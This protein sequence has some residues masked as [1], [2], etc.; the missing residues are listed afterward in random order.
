MVGTAAGKSKCITPGKSKL[1]KHGSIDTAPGANPK[2]SE[3]LQQSKSSKPGVDRRF[4]AKKISKENLQFFKGLVCKLEPIFR[5][6]GTTLEEFVRNATR[7]TPRDVESSG[8]PVPKPYK[9][10]GKK[11]SESPTLHHTLP[12]VNKVEE[13]DIVFKRGASIHWRPGNFLLRQ[14]IF[15]NKDTYRQLCKITRPKL[16]AM[17]VDYFKKTGFRFLEILNDKTGVPTYVEDSRLCEKFMQGLREKTFSGNS[18]VLPSILTDPNFHKVQPDWTNAQRPVGLLHK[19]NQ[20]KNN[21]TTKQTVNGTVK[22]K[23]PSKHDKQPISDRKQSRAKRKTSTEQFSVEAKIRVREQ[24]KTIGENPDL[25]SVSTAIALPHPVVTP[26]SSITTPSQTA[27]KNN[28][29]TL[30]VQRDLQDF[31]NKNCDSSLNEFMQGARLEVLVQF[32]HNG[33]PQNVQSS[34]IAFTTVVQTSDI[35]IGLVGL[36]HILPGN[37]LFRQ[38]MISNESFLRTEIVNQEMAARASSALV[39]HFVNFGFRFLGTTRDKCMYHEV[40]RRVVEETFQQAFLELSRNLKQPDSIKKR[41]LDAEFEDV[42]KKSRTSMDG[43][44]TSCSAV[45]MPDPNELM[46]YWNDKREKEESENEKRS[47]IL[48]FNESFRDCKRY[49]HDLLKNYYVDDEEIMRF[50]ADTE[51]E[52]MA[53]ILCPRTLRKKKSDRT[54]PLP[55]F[56]DANHRYS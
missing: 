31:F 32:Q 38:V 50:P 14:V 21:R 5:A 23:S 12:V 9:P 53:R 39:T 28:L 27:T 41:K 3:K 45:T 40:D 43:T 2:K 46:K 26:L 44:R 36:D 34:R 49:A 1:R 35:I 29:G 19:K 6:K 56:F 13:T 54:L 48:S 22:P 42:A 55:A 11:A 51:S 20:D 17:L 33:A 8:Q 25:T 37:W 7:W 47:L 24:I 52:S 4:P 15:M 18:L 10:P 30:R 16:A